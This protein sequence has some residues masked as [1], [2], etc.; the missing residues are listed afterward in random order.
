MVVGLDFDNTIVCY[1]GVFHRAAV[2]QGLVPA[3]IDQDKGSVRDYLRQVGREEDW[4][5]LQGYVYG[6][7]IG[8]ARPFP[9][10]FAFLAACVEH[11]SDVRVVSHKT[12]RPILGEPFDL[13]AAASGWLESNG[14]FDTPRTGLSPDRVSFELTKAAKCARIASVGCHYFVDD[15]PELLCDPAFPAGVTRILFNPSAGSP[16]PAGLLP[17]AGWGDVQTHVFSSVR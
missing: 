1:D 17:A 15:L 4:T 3:D 12:R 7:G 13:H 16:L 8:A 9:G 14:F 5:R 10:V 2:E 6:A 11:G